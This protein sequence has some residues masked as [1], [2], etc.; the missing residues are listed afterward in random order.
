MVIIA[1][2]EDVK[3][4][5]YILQCGKCDKILSY[6]RNDKEKY[7]F[8]YITDKGIS[9]AENRKFLFVETELYRYLKS[10]GVSSGEIKKAFELIYPINPIYN[11]CC[12]N[13]YLWIKQDRTI[14]LLDRSL[15][16]ALNEDAYK[17]VRGIEYMN[18]LYGKYASH[19]NNEDEG[20]D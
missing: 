8:G 7:K 2:S 12:F 5:K 10:I 19:W 6:N 20:N 13:N 15:A 1:I 17:E 18:N 4:V 11:K 9:H 14:N 3:M 16:D